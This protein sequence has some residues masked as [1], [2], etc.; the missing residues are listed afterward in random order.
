M[1]DEESRIAEYD[2]DAMHQVCEGL[3]WWEIRRWLFYYHWQMA[4]ILL[5]QIGGIV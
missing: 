1:T 2:R 3:D 5:R 4:E